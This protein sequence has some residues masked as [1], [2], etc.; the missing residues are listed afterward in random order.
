MALSDSHSL[1]ARCAG[2]YVNDTKGNHIMGTLRY[3]S[4]GFLLVSG[5]SQ[6]WS[7]HASLVWPLLSTDAE[8]QAPV[9]TPKPLGDFVEQQSRAIEEVLEA[10]EQWT[11][12]QGMEHALTPQALRFDPQRSDL[13][14]AFI[15][16][17]RINPTLSYAPYRQ[18]MAS[19]LPAALNQNTVSWD[20]LSFLEAGESHRAIPYVLLSASDLASPLVSPQVSPAHVLATA[21]DE[22]D[23]GMDVGL[24]ADNGTP[25]GA[26]YG[27]GE[28]PFGNPNLSYGSQAPFHMGFYHLDWL[29]KKAQPGLLNTYPIWRIA[30]Y[31]RLAE[32]AFATGNDYWGWRFMGWALHYIGDLTQPYHAVP[33]PGVSTSGALWLVIKGQTNDAI[34]LVSNRH[35][36]LESYQYQRLSKALS[37]DEASSMWLTTLSNPESVPAELSPTDVQ[38][39]LTLESVEAAAALDAGLA[40]YVPSRYV[41]DASFEWVGSGLEGD[42]ANLIRADGGDEAIRQLDAIVT[43]QLRRFVRFAQAWVNRTQ[44]HNQE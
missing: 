5:Q 31:D 2:L 41:S 14:Q 16:A 6:A 15:Q 27:F 26:I 23:R 17:I 12:A 37:G 19:E 24:F 35:G 33:L 11:A 4:L 9:L 25:F 36:V 8:L 40:K 43:R 34:Q 44:M 39:Y 21:S 22:P 38:S 42:V 29:T 18:L 20:D 10:H 3:L 1:P 30:L 32:L 13:V 28:Q 7:D